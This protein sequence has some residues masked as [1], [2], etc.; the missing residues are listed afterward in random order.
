MEKIRKIKFTAV[1]VKWFDRINGNTY[2]SVRITRHRNGKELV[3]PFTYGYD[4]AYE[5]TA[6]QAMADAKWIPP[7]Y[8]R[9]MDG[10]TSSYENLWAYQRENNY[11]ILF[12]VSDGLK[13]ECIANGT[14]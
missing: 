13:R 4:S 8:R 3:C 6:L 9:S 12:T 5:Q 2:H 10:M 14:T 7:K 1:V 11:P